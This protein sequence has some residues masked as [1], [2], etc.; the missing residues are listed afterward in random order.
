MCRGGSS[1]K[2]PPFNARATAPGLTLRGRF[3]CELVRPGNVGLCSGEGQKANAQ[4]KTPRHIVYQPG[5][6][7]PGAA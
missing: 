7:W 3:S 6:N 5:K 1:G 4:A 2:P